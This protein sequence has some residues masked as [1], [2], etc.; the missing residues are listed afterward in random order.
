MAFE[1]FAT[2]SL[3]RVIPD[4]VELEALNIDEIEMQA[5][6]TESPD[7]AFYACLDAVLKAT[8]VQQCLTANDTPMSEVLR[9]K[10]FTALADS[11][12][13]YAV[14]P[15]SET[16]KADYANIVLARRSFV[17]VFGAHIGYPKDIVQRLENRDL[18]D[19]QIE[20][21][22]VSTKMQKAEEAQRQGFVKPLAVA[23]EE[24]LVHKYGPNECAAKLSTALAQAVFDE[25]FY[26]ERSVQ[27][28]RYVREANQYSSID[29]VMLW[30]TIISFARAAR[31]S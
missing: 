29:D 30:D 11:L 16:P 15:D 10:L 18:M 31:L 21:V 19:L 7:H 8:A 14:S 3:W 12:H 23:L 17:E 13:K 20:S 25:A 26:G 24:H 1:V 9:M 22:I 28:F 4:G 2:P 6:D 27:T 5:Q